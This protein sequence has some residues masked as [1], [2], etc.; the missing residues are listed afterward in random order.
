M[1]TNNKKGVTAIIGTILILLITVAVAGILW[2]VVVPMVKKGAAETELASACVSADI[3]ISAKD[4]FYN[5]TLTTEKFKVVVSRGAG[6]L[7]L[8]DIQI[9]AYNVAG[10]SESYLIKEKFGKSE[11]PDENMQKVY[12]LNATIA[13]IKAALA[14]KLNVGDTAKFCTPTAKVDIETVQ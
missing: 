8:N 13:P 4:S 3:K 1:I 2:Q 11:L 7:D 5:Q 9:I 10:S 14:I 12:N 6:E